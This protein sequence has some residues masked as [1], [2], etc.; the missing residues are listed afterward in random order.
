MR[1]KKFWV[2]LV[3][4]LENYEN[5]ILL[6]NPRNP[7]LSPKNIGENNYQKLIELVERL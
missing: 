3:P 2:E 7:T 6:R 5:K 1:S 4:E